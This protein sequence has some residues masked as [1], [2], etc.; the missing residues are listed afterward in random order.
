MKIAFISDIHANIFALEQ[1]YEDL[2]KEKVEKILVAGDLIG[3]YYWPKKV[4]DLLRS[5]Q[6][7][8]CIQ[9]NHEVI[10][11]EIMKST[12]SAEKYKK[13]FGSGYRVCID[14]L[15]SSDI[16]WLGNLPEEISISF[17]DFSI[18]M[19]HGT[20]NSIDSYLYPNADQQKILENYSDD[21][22]TVFG[23]SH[24][25]FIHSHNN[26]YI[27]NPGS[28]GQ[29]RDIGGLASYAIFDSLNYTFRF[30]R[31]PFQTNKIIETVESFDP[32]N[33]YLKDIMER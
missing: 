22:I 6:R 2:D 16:D 3:Y 13:K 12:E 5:D 14:Q 11:K 32:T 29:P 23:H 33:L 28:V 10:L 24:H 21:M 15:D 31:L 18:F 20:L 1:V 9:G 4:I 19:K 26:K 8:I 25:P 30:K 7:F 17:E 27:L